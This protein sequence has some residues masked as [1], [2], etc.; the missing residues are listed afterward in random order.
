MEFNLLAQIQAKRKSLTDLFEKKQCFTDPEVV[1]LSQELDILIL[2]YQL[3][4]KR[5]A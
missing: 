2:Q 1:K 3:E 5:Y 4:K